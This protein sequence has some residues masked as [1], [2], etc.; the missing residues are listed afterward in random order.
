MIK[1]LP[2]V[3]SGVFGLTQVLDGGNVIATE[4]YILCYNSNQ[5]YWISAQYIYKGLLLAF[6]TFL[7]WETRHVRI[8]ALNDSREI[9]FCVYNVVVIC[10]FG[11]P[12]Y[13]LLSAN[14]SNLRFLISSSLIIFCTTLVLCIVFI[15]KV[16][17]RT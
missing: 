15:P 12:V 1:S 13:H 3:L 8:A 4:T 5:L 14:Q 16:R 7:A 10:V 17:N 6:G 9:G 2:L 11:V